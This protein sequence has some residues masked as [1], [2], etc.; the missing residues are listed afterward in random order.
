MATEALYYM[1]ALTLEEATSIYTDIGLT[2]LAADGFYSNTAISRQQL[3]GLLQAQTT[4]DNC[5]SPPPTTATLYS[6]TQNVTNNI[7]GT[8][9]VNYS[10]SGSGYDGSGAPG[11]VTQTGPA[12]S[13]Y[14]FEIFAQALAGFQFS[15][16][17]P[18][19]A[20]NPD[21]LIPP[22][23]GGTTVT[24]TL[25]GSIEPIPTG[26]TVPT[27]FYKLNGCANSN[28]SVP[29]GGWIERVSGAG[30]ATNQRFVTSN[31]NPVEY[32]VYDQATSPQSTVPAQDQL[33]SSAGRGLSLSV[34]AGET[35]CPSFNVVNENIYELRKCSD[36]TTDYYF[37]STTTIF[38][39]G[40]RV[41][42]DS[43][44]T[45]YIIEQELNSSQL[46]GKA[47]LFNVLEV[48]QNGVAKGQPG[49]TIGAVGCPGTYWVLRACDPEAQIL[50]GDRVSVQPTNDPIFNNGGAGSVYRDSVEAIC[51]ELYETTTTPNQ[52]SSSTSPPV[53][54]TTYVGDDCQ[55]CTVSG[56]FGG[57][58]S[59]LS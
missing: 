41:T 28:G 52:Y 29:A 12:Q 33:E 39:P 32:F 6:V 19:T 46:S 37:K 23:S 42:N 51:W 14:D 36:N 47:E 8:L 11:P 16:T 3:N 58:F 4:C 57:G 9:G 49:F 2:T 25:T 21:G 43:G 10:L 7:V 5:A 53:Q 30:P 13:P 31:T 34:L 17:A 40:T 22:D 50:N 26:V 1:D 24:N 59:Y 15:S 38:L 18:F 56:G 20:T 54:I 35:G 45:I 55:A 27:L 44:S 48:D